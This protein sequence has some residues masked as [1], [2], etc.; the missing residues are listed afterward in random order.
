MAKKQFRASQN[1]V[2]IHLSGQL[3]SNLSEKERVEFWPLLCVAP[4]RQKWKAP[5]QVYSIYNLVYFQTSGIF[6]SN[7]YGKW[8]KLGLILDIRN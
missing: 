6:P 7:S 4:Y 5:T 2:L 8:L 1:V 3:L